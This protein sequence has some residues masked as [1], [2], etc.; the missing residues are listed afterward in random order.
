MFNKYRKMKYNGNVF[1]NVKIQHITVKKYYSNLH[2]FNKMQDA[3][4]A[5][6][7]Q[8]HCTLYF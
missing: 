6:Y 3:P 5:D 1:V 4:A 8:W 2:T 7:I